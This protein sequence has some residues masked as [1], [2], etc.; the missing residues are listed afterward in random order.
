MRGGRLRPP[1]KTPFRNPQA[2]PTNKLIAIAAGKG[3]CRS[4][5]RDP[6]T[7]AHSARI[8]P[9]D[10][11][12]PPVMMIGVTAN[13][14]SPSSTLSRITS[15]KLAA[16]KKCSAANAKI[17]HSQARTAR[18]IHSLLGKSLRVSDSSLSGTAGAREVEVYMPVKSADS[19]IGKD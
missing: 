16:V 12:M 8:E 6:N 19:R 2:H 3:V 7:T 11:S 4:R 5:Q 15:N 14:S 17:R 18:R 9:T 1:I 10:K 13:E